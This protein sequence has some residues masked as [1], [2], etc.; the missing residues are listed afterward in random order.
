[1]KSYNKIKLSKG[2]CVKL[3]EIGYYNYWYPGSSDKYKTIITC[4][5]VVEHLSL[6]KNQGEYIAFKAPSRCV[7]TIGKV[8]EDQY[9][10]IWIKK[11][12]VEELVGV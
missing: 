12:K 7:K 2:T 10:C 11:N 8:P 5:T 3:S 4:D 1:M 6:W 9:V